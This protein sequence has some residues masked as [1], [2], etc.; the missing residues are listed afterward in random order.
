M[1]PECKCTANKVFF[2]QYTYV[3]LFSSERTFSCGVA[4]QLNLLFVQHMHA[5]CDE[6]YNFTRPLV[7][8]QTFTILCKIYHIGGWEGGH[9]DGWGTIKTDLN[10][11]HSHCI[12][13]TS[14]ATNL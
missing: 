13:Y 7:W 1:L 2:H 8:Q 9:R 14:K 6:H 5:T 12:L 3:T 10:K 4:Q 11:P